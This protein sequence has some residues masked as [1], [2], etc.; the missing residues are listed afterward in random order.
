[1]NSDRASIL[2]EWEKV[3]LWDLV[4][5]EFGFERDFLTL[6]IIFLIDFNELIDEI[7]D[8]G[9][10]YQTMLI[11]LCSFAL[12][13]CLFCVGRKKIFPTKL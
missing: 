13:I 9:S 1:M 6:V 12:F 4:Y 10:K 7:V 2:F 11:F 5:F 3:V 8:V